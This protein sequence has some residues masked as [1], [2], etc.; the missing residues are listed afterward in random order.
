MEDSAIIELYWRRS[1]Q[2]VGETAA[3]YGPYCMKI[4]MNILSDLQESEEN[5]ND[6][7]LQAWNSMPPHRPDALSAFLGRLARNLALNRYKAGRAE[8]RGGSELTLSLEELDDCT[9]SGMRTEQKLYENALSDSIS[10]FLKTQGEQA[11]RT[12]VRRYF[13]CDSIE[14]IA[15][16]FNMSQSKVKSLL[17]RT[18]NKL[19]IYLESEGFIY[20]K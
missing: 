17:F 20:E 3:K 7:Y 4:S 11:R 14:E 10:A 5:V 6:T 18:R 19:R 8:K 9:P 16:R 13:F 1:E 15:G 12:F 2:A